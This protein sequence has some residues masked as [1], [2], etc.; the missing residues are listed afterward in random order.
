MPETIDG[1]S[2]ESSQLLVEARK[3]EEEAVAIDAVGKRAGGLEFTKAGIFG[4]YVPAYHA[5]ED[6]IVARCSE[7]MTEMGR[8]R[9]TLMRIAQLYEQTEANHSH[10]IKSSGQLK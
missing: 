5:L 2:V 10:E 1:F 7:G 6:A 9:D 3:W 8:N 4:A